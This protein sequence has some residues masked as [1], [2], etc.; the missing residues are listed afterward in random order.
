MGIFKFEINYEHL[1]QTYWNH[2][3]WSYEYHL[4][5]SNARANEL[6]RQPFEFPFFLLFLLETR[7]ESKQ[8]L[9]LQNWNYFKEKPKLNLFTSAHASLFSLSKS[10]MTELSLVALTTETSLVWV[11]LGQTDV[12]EY[13]ADADVSNSVTFLISASRS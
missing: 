9:Q 10:S 7:I 8:I 4:W 13:R 12:F 3:H 1:R 2:Q 11:W 6:N 5:L